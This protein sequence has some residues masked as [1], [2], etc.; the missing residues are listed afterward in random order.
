MTQTSLSTAILQTEGLTRSFGGQVAVNDVSLAVRQGEF[1]S[2]I[3]P[4]GA[5]KTT[6]FNLISGMLP[7]SAG[8]IIF[9]GE[10]ITGRPAYKR[11]HAGIGRS[12]QMNTI[13]PNLT[14]LENVRLAAQSRGKHAFNFWQSFKRFQHDE[15]KAYAILEM[16]MLGGRELQLAQTLSHGDKRK[17]EIGMLLATDPRILL[18]DEPTAGMS[19]DDVPGIIEV[20]QRI[21]RAGGR[22]VMLV[23]HKMDMVMSVSDSVMVMHYGQLIADGTPQEIA[24]NETVQSAYLGSYTERA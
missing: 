12:F 17:L 8:K 13:F 5:G 21:K 18:L 14:V 10:D 20:V 11:S 7:P 15:E 24:Q 19:R 2:I 6:L 3:G 22:T 4:N 23:E 9:E 1:K 16:V